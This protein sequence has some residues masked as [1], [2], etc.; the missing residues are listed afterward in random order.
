VGAR[1]FDAPT[2][3]NRSGLADVVCFAFEYQRAEYGTAHRADD[4]V[5]VQGRTGVKVAT[6]A[7]LGQHRSGELDGD[8]ARRRGV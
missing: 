6:R 4:L 3:Q 2:V 7:D 1:E 8:G 5:L